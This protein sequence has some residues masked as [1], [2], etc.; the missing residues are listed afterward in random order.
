M[1]SYILVI[2]ILIQ[3]AGVVVAGLIAWTTLRRS[4][5]LIAFAILLMGVR[6]AISL[7]QA[8]VLDQS[9]DPIAESVA[10]LISL[11]MFLGFLGLLLKMRPG[12]ALPSFEW[13]RDTGTPG[14]IAALLGVLIILGTS[15]VAYYAFQESR[16]AMVESVIA[17][18]QR[19]ADSLVS[20]A[21]S[22]EESLPVSAR[23]DVV[24]DIWSKDPLA[25]EGSY[26]CIVGPDGRVIAHSADRSSQ[27]RYV[28]GDAVLDRSRRFSDIDDLLEA[29]ADWS[30]WYISTTGERQV[31]AF[32]YSAT[33]P[34]LVAVH[35]P[36]RAI[37]KAV[38]RVALPPTAGMLFILVVLLPAALGV[39]YKAYHTTL[40]E[41]QSS[42]ARYRAVVDDQTELI[43]RSLPD[44]T[45]TFVNEA[46]CRCFGL[47][48]DE[49]VGHKFLPAIPYEDRAKVNEHFA[50]LTRE[51][52]VAAYEHRVVLP[53]GETRWFGWSNH[54]I[55]DAGGAIVEIQGIGRD[56]TERKQARAQ[57]DEFDARSSAIIENAVDGIVTVDEQGVIESV[58]PAA[59]ELFG[60]THSGLIGRH[61]SALLP[62]SP[63]IGPD[64][65]GGYLSQAGNP[66]GINC[67][68]EARGTRNDGTAFPVKLSVSEVHFGDR[69]LFTAI[70]HDL[71]RE[72]ELEQQLLRAQ[73][74]DALGTLAG[75]IAHDFNNILHALLGF[76]RLAQDSTEGDKDLLVQCLSEIEAGG[77]RATDL[78]GQILTF[79]R[80]ADVERQSVMLEPLLKE[81]LRF[82]RSS[83]PVTIGF[84][85]RFDSAC[86]EVL[87][88]ATQFHQVVTNLCTNAMH[89]MEEKGG[90]LTVSL[91]PVAID[92]PLQTLSGMLNPG[93]YIQLAVADS[94]TGIEPDLLPRL[95][96]PFFTTK[97]P[98]KGVGL[99]LAM[100]HA[101]V[102]GTGGGLTIESEVGKGSTIR[103]LLPELRDVRS[104]TERELPA[105]RADGVTGRVLLVDDESSITQM[106][107]LHLESQGFDVESY[108]DAARA[109]EAVRSDPA[110]F[111]VAVIDYTMPG[112]TGVVLAREILALNP[113]LP[114][115]LTTGNLDRSKIEPPSN[116][117]EIL[118]KPF[119]AETLLAI[120]DRCG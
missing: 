1:A 55:C 110:R 15:I 9:L 65:I 112:K 7:Y 34:G 104:P 43:Y 53:D 108:N 77:L 10:L 21:D 75:G 102:A 14:V 97:E 31:A 19:V 56:V 54:V 61:L 90:T 35:V 86:G 20:V 63:R 99:G 60:Y 81:A 67:A 68:R 4:W 79:S 30:G 64:E 100:V 48:G 91:E 94:G 46:Y 33:L 115:I 49:L 11:F 71:T 88:N 51:H 23:I 96:D 70:V 44:G 13:K 85:T 42:E 37:E 28:G 116:V 59:L 24:E 39:L 76:C 52:P 16:G 3:L 32:S 83:I 113:A 120:I 12:V 47:R 2:S 78:V 119:R 25:F 17:L 72:R 62:D 118:N 93:H 57:K 89:A 26:I 109:L 87:V 84:E 111:I 82:L 107:A 5:L 101:I 69:R 74:L 98:G 6:R 95:L 45:L 58:N 73:K 106:L 103:V 117:I 36:E 40:C 29:R 41:V 38:L 8:F 22:L 27:G 18:N 92:A 50:S 114:V 80:K 105:R 66:T